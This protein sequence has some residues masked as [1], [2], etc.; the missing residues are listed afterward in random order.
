MTDDD[1]VT[2]IGGITRLDIPPNQVLTAALDKI[3]PVIVIGGDE[4]DRIYIASSTG[5]PKRVLWLLELAKRRMFELYEG[6][7]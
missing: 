1:N 5:D 7:P 4:D 6:L 2:P 3:D